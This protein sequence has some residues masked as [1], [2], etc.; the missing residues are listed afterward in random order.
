MCWFYAGEHILLTRLLN[1]QSKYKVI[2]LNRHECR[3]ERPSSE[4]WPSAFYWFVYFF[5]T[6]LHITF[7]ML[8]AGRP[9]NLTI[10]GKDSRFLCSPRRS[11]RLWDPPSLLCNAYRG[12]FPLEVKRTGRKADRCPPHSPENNA[13]SCTSLP[14]MCL[15]GVYKDI[16]TVYIAYP[17]VLLKG[18]AIPL[19]AWTGGFQEVEA[20]KFQGN[21]RM[22]W[23]SCQP[24]AP[25]AFTPPHPQEIFLVLISVRGWV[26][27]R[28]IVRSEELCRWKIPMTPSGI[29][30]ATFRLVA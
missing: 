28:A 4:S 21:R 14:P 1:V 29:E 19:Q 15:R 3:D 12:L 27:P 11:N 24:Y 17:V 16:C 5:R 6:Y 13:W 23:K 7:L 8:R 9:R 22:K 20:S 25:T 2:S 26:N 10:F 18:T 30:T